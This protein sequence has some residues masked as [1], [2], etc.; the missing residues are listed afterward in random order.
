[1][2]SGIPGG[3][4]VRVCDCFALKGEE[5]EDSSLCWELPEERPEGQ[6]IARALCS[7]LAHLEP[8]FLSCFEL[9]AWRSTDH[10]QLWSTW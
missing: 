6:D 9:W 7:R 8:T 5:S 2:A 1:M 10:T 3:R 4:S